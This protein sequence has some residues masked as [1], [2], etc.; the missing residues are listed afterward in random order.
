VI[1]AAITEL[2]SVLSASAGVVGIALGGSRA[3]GEADPGSDWDLGVYYRGA[4]DLAPLA[5]YGTVHAPGAWGRIMNGGAWLTLDGVRVDVL[6]RDLDVVEPVA[7]AARRGEFQVEALLGY[8][9]GA[10]TYL[11]LAELAIGRTLAGSVPAAG[12]YPSALRASAPPRWRFSS[13]FS[14]DHARTRADRGDRIGAVGQVSKA[15]LEAAHA[16]LAARGAW[17]VNEKRLVER[18]GLAPL[19]AVMEA[20]ARQALLSDWV[21]RVRDE[22][23]ARLDPS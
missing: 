11:L 18:A 2:V 1:P 7:A 13:H 6:L 8:L 16:I 14:L 3:T 20:G 19:H 15:I 12:E 17:V 5:R 22:L 9:A 4:I 10:P 21:A 23:R